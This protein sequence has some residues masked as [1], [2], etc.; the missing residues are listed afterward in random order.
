MELKETSNESPRQTSRHS[1]VRQEIHLFSKFLG[2]IR[3][4]LTSHETSQNDMTYD[5]SYVLVYYSVQNLDFISITRKNFRP[6][7]LDNETVIAD[8]TDYVS[9]LE[10]SHPIFINTTTDILSAAIIFVS[11]HKDHVRVTPLTIDATPLK[12]N[13][14]FNKRTGNSFNSTFINTEETLQ[15]TK[16]VYH[17]RFKPHHLFNEEVVE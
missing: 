17:K 1:T 2:T 8:Q 3:E 6:Q 9:D 15:G 10:W 12:Y 16:I 7:I 13:S 11:V 4:N 5:K 14:M